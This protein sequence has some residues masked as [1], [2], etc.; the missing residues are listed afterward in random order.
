MADDIILPLEEF[1]ES[2][3][4]DYGAN[5]FSDRISR[6]SDGSVGTTGF[7]CKVYYRNIGSNDLFSATNFGNMTI[8]RAIDG[9]RSAQSSVTL[10][11][12]EGISF[13][14]LYFCVF[15]EDPITSITAPCFIKQIDNTAYSSGGTIQINNFKL[16]FLNPSRVLPVKFPELDPFSQLGNV[17]GRFKGGGLFLFGVPV[18]IISEQF[19]GG[20]FFNFV[21]DAHITDGSYTGGGF[22]NFDIRANSIKASYTGGGEFN[23]IENLLYATG[24]FTGDGLFNFDY[25]AADLT[26]NDVTYTGDG[27]FNATE[28]VLYFTTNGQMTGDGRMS[29][30]Y[31]ISLADASFTGDGLY[32]FDARITRLPNL[33]NNSFTGGGSFDFNQLIQINIQEQVFTGG[34]SFVS[35]QYLDAGTRQ[36]DFTGGGF[37]DFTPVKL[38]GSQAFTG[39]GQFSFA[40]GSGQ[41]RIT[42]SGET[43]ILEDGTIR[44]IE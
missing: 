41:E 44:I 37:M 4:T 1:S 32:N 13:D 12:I 7:K 28:N 42:E 19:T 27:F 30:D 43:R 18:G 39:D 6:L 3:W 24:E 25:R 8:Y 9:I 14:E 33:K 22:A 38:L 5:Y 2:G 35:D 29:F 21:E 34:G 10:N 26:I 15:Y 36:G 23:F 16:S 11:F 20:G 31:A 40:I 17:N